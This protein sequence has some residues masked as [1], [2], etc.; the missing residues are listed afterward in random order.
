[1]N[2]QGS[3]VEKEM[4]EFE[5]TVIDQRDLSSQKMKVNETCVA[6][7]L[8]KQQQLSAD[9]D[10]LGEIRQ[11]IDNRRQNDSA[12]YLVYLFNRVYE[13]RFGKQASYQEIKKT[14][15]DFVLSM[16]GA[17]QEKIES[18]P[19]PLA[20]SLAF[21]RIGNYIDFGAMNSID[22]ST[23]LALLD[24]ARLQ[25]RDLQTFHSFIRQCEQAERFLLVA[26]NCGEIVLDKLFLMQ[27][28]KA[29]P[30]LT[31]RV[32]VRGGEVLNDATAE[33]ALYVHLD[34]VAH[35]VSNGN[36]VAGT[37]FEM[38]S[39]E[40]KTV[41]DEADV[42][43]A[44]GQGNYESICGQGR[45]VFYSFLCKCDLFTGRFKVPLLTGLFLEETE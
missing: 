23:L 34:E 42:I 20:T 8:D 5:S 45:H 13:R 35:I 18:S 6:C 17:I 9:Q 10:Y 12:P 32:M 15:N 11:I 33:D 14:Y 25:E 24:D 37:I 2:E 38:L 29:F 43:L 28:K 27:L 26:D 41:M 39:E 19:D 22:E 16:E 31:I 36:P 40:A 3:L 4:T 30:R 44:K 7:L 21:A 1:M